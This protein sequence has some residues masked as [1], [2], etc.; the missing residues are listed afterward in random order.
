MQINPLA[1]TGPSSLSS[2][3]Q[4]FGVYQNP[5]NALKCRWRG[6][7]HSTSGSVGL[8]WGPRICIFSKLSG[9][10]AASMGNTLQ[11][12]LYPKFTWPTETNSLRERPSDV[13]C[14]IPPPRCLGD[15]SHQGDLGKTVNN[16]PQVRH[17]HYVYYFSNHLEQWFSTLDAY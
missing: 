8:A 15:S 5:M 12:I 17:D 4:I 10:A 11:T 6:Y 13:D 16:S 1:L 7:T 3:S 2:S 14:S 9:T